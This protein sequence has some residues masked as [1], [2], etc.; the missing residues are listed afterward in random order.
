[1]N[2]SGDACVNCILTIF[3]CHSVFKIEMSEKK[4]EESRE[5]NGNQAYKAKAKTP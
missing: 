5:E 3:G 1:M 2:I 4:R